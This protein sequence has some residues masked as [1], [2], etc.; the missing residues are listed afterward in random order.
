MRSIYWHFERAELAEWC[1]SGITDDS[2]SKG[3]F[4]VWITPEEARHVHDDLRQA[5]LLHTKKLP[6]IVFMAR[7]ILHR[8]PN[9]SGYISLADDGMDVIECDGY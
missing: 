3:Y 8:M 1:F 5:A 4:N 2:F 9:T 6:E 7:H